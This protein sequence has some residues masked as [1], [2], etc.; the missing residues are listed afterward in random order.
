ML[1]HPW[2][3]LT[4]LY[5]DDCDEEIKTTYY[6]VYGN[7]VVWHNHEK[8]S[9]DDE[10]KTFSFNDTS[11]QGDENNAHREAQDIDASFAELAQG[12]PNAAG[13]NVDEADRLGWRDVDDVDWMPCV[14]HEQINMDFWKEAKGGVSE[15]YDLDDVQGDYYGLGLKQKLAYDIIINFAEIWMK[16]QRFPGSLAAPG[17]LLM[18]VDGQGGTGKTHVVRLISQRMKQLAEQYGVIG[19]IVRRAAPTGVAAFNINGRTLHSLFRL[20]IKTK[21]YENLTLENKRYLQNHFKDVGFLIIDEKS[22]IGLR[23]LYFLDRRL[24]EIFPDVDE[25][26][27]GINVILMG[28]FYQLPTVG[29]TPLYFSTKVNDPV[30][31]QGQRLYRRFNETI[32]LDVVKRQAGLDSRAVAFRECLDRLRIDQIT[33]RDWELLSTRVQTQILDAKKAKFDSAIRLFGTKEKVRIYNHTKL[34]DLSVPVVNITASHTGHKKA[35]DVSTEEAG[36]L[37]PILSVSINATVMLRENLWVSKG[38][39][40]GRTGFVRNVV[41]G[42]HVTS[43]RIESPDMLL[44]YIPGYN[45]PCYK[46]VN[47]EKLVPIYQSKREFMYRGHQAC[48]RTQFPVVLAYAMTVHKSQGLSIDKAVLNITDREFVPGLTYVAVSRV[49]SLSGL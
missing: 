29:E 17:L 24:R 38:L 43:P 4:D 25:D 1:H 37:Q 45:G 39:V 3:A 42:G 2:R 21:K 12:L 34:R 33:I 14:A 5:Y 30:I 13:D 49:R 27:G 47:G 7:C 6:S 32:T 19:E 10:D 15:D 31:T 22:M 23:I 18:H 40:N 36:N 16:A 8:D 35:V 41:W 20:P 26:F 46:E 44:L 28:D 9:L 11:T 48:T